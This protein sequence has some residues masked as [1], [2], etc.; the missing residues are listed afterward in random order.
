[1]E[2]LE[3]RI[4]LDHAVAAAGALPDSAS[5]AFRRSKA[6]PLRKFGHPRAALAWAASVGKT[7]G[8]LGLT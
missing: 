4:D 1:M 8:R 3:H 2:H 7:L 6:L 5:A